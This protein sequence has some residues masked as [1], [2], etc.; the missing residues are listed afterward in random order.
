MFRLREDDDEMANRAGGRL[1]KQPRTKIPAAALREPDVALKR[2]PREALA[3]VKRNG[4]SKDFE[5]ANSWGADEWEKELKEKT[6][7][8]EEELE[9]PHAN[10]EQLIDRELNSVT[11]RR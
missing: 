2:L 7:Q 4:V 11:Q 9:K 5:L 3:M 8:L 10:S 6:L 1:T